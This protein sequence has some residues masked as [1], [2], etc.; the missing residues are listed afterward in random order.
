M[1]KD[2]KNLISVWES[3]EQEGGG[4]DG[5]NLIVRTE[6]DGGRRVSQEYG[7]LCRKF[8]KL[9]EGGASGARRVVTKF[10]KQISFST[11]S[12]TSLRP[13]ERAGGQRKGELYLLPL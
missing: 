2:I 9:E 10:P 7:N 11:L 1:N 4:M 13:T 5:V 6:T 3:S 8:E 12:D